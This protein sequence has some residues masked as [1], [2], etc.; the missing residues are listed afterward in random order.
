MVDFVRQELRKETGEKPF[1]VTDRYD[2]SSSLAFYLP[3]HP[4]VYSVMSNVGGRQSQY[5]I[6]PGLEKGHM[7]AGL[8]GR[9]AVVVQFMGRKPLEKLMTASFEHWTGPVV[10]PVV[11]EGVVVQTVA[12]YKAYGFKGV[13][14]GFGKGGGA[15]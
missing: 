1:V 4:F 13:P 7:D 3:G 12:V 11:Y 15:W 5:D 10:L 8:L 2:R 6:W 9:P 14:A